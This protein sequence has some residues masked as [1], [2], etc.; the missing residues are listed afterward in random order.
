MTKPFHH[1]PQHAE[2]RP[3]LFRSLLWVFLTI[4][5]VGNAVASAIGAG[6]AAHLG[7][8]AVTAVCT[9]ALVVQYLR[10]R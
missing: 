4:G 10:R 7:F 3:Q 9:I 8:G 6:I 2:P 5:V 1:T